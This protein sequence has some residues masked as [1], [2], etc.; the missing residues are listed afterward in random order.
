MKT[1][2]SHLVA[3]LLGASLVILLSNNRLATSSVRKS[4]ENGTFEPTDVSAAT[5]ADTPNETLARTHARE[6]NGRQA[7]ESALRIT[8]NVERL[9]VLIEAAKALA[10]EGPGG[11][12]A[13]D[14]I[15]HL[16]LK[17]VA[18]D[19]FFQKLAESHPESALAKMREVKLPV[20]FSA[21]SAV[22]QAMVRKNPVA[23]GIEAASTPPSP[24]R[25]RL[26]SSVAGEWGAVDPKAAF[27]WAQSL[28]SSAEQNQTALAVIEATAAVKPDTAVWL[29]QML[30]PGKSRDIAITMAAA[31]QT[32]VNPDVAIA[33][34]SGLPVAEQRKAYEGIIDRLS[35]EDPRKAAMLIDNLPS[36]R[37][38]K[39]LTVKIAGELALSDWQSAKAWLAQREE[40]HLPEMAAPVLW[41]MGQQAPMDAAALLSEI[42]FHPELAE[43]VAQIAEN[44]FGEAGPVEAVKWA[45]NIAD[46]AMKESAMKEVFSAWAKS[47]PSEALQNA[48]APAAKAAVL[49]V[50]A[51]TQPDTLFRQFQNEAADTSTDIGG[52]YVMALAAQQPETAYRILASM[53]GEA[54]S[55]AAN[56]LAEA[57]GTGDPAAAAA[58]SLSLPVSIGSVFRESVLTHWLGDDPAGASAWIE[59]LP[60]GETR[61]SSIAIMVTTIRAADPERATMWLTQIEDKRLREQIAAPSP[62]T[63]KTH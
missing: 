41:V 26:V 12:A 15:S 33:W 20:E 19:A 4:M 17:R 50:L 2:V 34:A 10:T 56:V 57:W 36:G 48:S 54:A 21:W 53:N 58:A 9:N 8:D 31:Y 38:R 60:K 24:L 61:D 42:N 62:D 37:I 35:S 6:I 28:P 1:T 45:Q 27:A 14:A 3:A 25:D 51:R 40:L 23:A 7:L 22:M 49:S 11:Y 47:N 52:A 18:S 29:A 5:A 59:S 16:T 30:P 46:E 55:N 32:G 13:I 44:Y 63:I 43:H 39:D